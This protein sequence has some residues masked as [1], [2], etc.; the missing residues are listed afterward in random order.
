M[1]SLVIGGGGFIGSHLCKAL[2]K[3]GNQVI[4]IDNFSI[5]TKSNIQ[6]IKQNND[7]MLYEA[8]ASIKK[9][10]DDIFKKER[11]EYVFHL[12]A[13]SDIQASASKFT[14]SSPKNILFSI[15]F[16]QITFNG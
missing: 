9:S 1:K 6:E 7:F 2:L 8:D 3:A 15:E 14:F 11:P 16:L 4:C 13:N 10:L 5:G 12:A